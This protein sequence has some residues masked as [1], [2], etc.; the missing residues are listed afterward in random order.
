MMRKS[1]IVAI[2]IILCFN[3]FN[4][5]CTEVYDL[6]TISRRVATLRQCIGMLVA[7][8][9]DLLIVAEW[10]QLK[11]ITRS[12]ISATIGVCKRIL[13]LLEYR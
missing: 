10:E 2:L 13:E 11:P 5:M 3:T 12:K 7:Q 1:I 9:M 6:E 8:L 4:A